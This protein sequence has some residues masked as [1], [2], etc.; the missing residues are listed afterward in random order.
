MEQ[1]LKPF[2]ERNA[3][4]LKK[5][6]RLGEIADTFLKLLDENQTSNRESL[7]VLRKVEAVCR[8]KF[9]DCSER[10]EK[11][12]EICNAIN[13]AL[14]AGKTV[15][16]NDSTSTT[17]IGGAVPGFGLSPNVHCISD[18]CESDGSVK[19]INTKGYIIR[20]YF[21]EEPNVDII[22]DPGVDKSPLR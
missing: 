10:P 17:Q 19:L 3:E 2:T 1:K 8:R 14:I 18:V 21:P 9:P 13:T 6:Q 20:A 5:E 7:R 4:R 11:A 12:L 16:L 15:T 22:Y